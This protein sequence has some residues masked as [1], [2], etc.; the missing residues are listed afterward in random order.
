MRVGHPWRGILGA[1]GGRAVGLDERRVGQ[2][3]STEQRHQQH[4][5]IVAPNV[6]HGDVEESK[7]NAARAAVDA[8]NGKEILVVVGHGKQERL[9]RNISQR[10][11]A[12]H[13]H[14]VGLGR[15]DNGGDKEQKLGVLNVHVRLGAQRVQNVLPAR[16]ME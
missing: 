12:Q 16:N 14:G 4:G 2:L 3:R 8:T 1:S 5:G 9:R 10:V 6:I 15:R 13:R 11:D 7:G